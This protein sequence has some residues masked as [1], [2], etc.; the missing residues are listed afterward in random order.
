MEG[1]ERGQKGVPKCT[2]FLIFHGRAWAIPAIDIFRKLKTLSPVLK[3]ASRGKVR[4]KIQ[5][6]ITFS[7]ALFPMIF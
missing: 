3:V 6:L 5:I 4:I 7:K 2:E 1:P